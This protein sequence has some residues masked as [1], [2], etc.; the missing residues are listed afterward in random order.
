MTTNG[1]FSC[2]SWSSGQTP[3]L[4]LFP[5]PDRRSDICASRAH[6]IRGL[7]CSISFSELH[8]IGTQIQLA[9][10]QARNGLS[11]R[12]GLPRLYQRDEYHTLAVQLGSALDSWEDSLPFDWKL[13]NLSIVKDR[14]AR[15]ERYLLHFRYVNQLASTQ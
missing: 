13:Q 9:Q 1:S 2:V 3:V 6:E 14:A 12:L 15:A 7:D 11:A 4:S 8:E 5:M 10:T